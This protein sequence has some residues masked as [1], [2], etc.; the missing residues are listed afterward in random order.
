[1]Y[2]GVVR[3]RLICICARVRRAHLDYG[4]K[5][6]MPAARYTV[7]CIV[8]NFFADT[9][10]RRDA[11][12]AAGRLCIYTYRALFAMRCRWIFIDLSTCAQSFEIILACL[13]VCLNS[14]RIYL[15]GIYLYSVFLCTI[16]ISFSIL[17]SSNLVR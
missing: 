8:F 16:V 6:L 15:F 17:M 12:R 1:M 2:A 3:E 14:S 13:S 10:A 7:G 5:T 9:S 4:K 11:L